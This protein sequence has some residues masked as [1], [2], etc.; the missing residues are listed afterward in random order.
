LLLYT[1]A[2][3]YL[4]DRSS[5]VAGV[6]APDAASIDGQERSDTVRV[7]E[8]RIVVMR[9]ADDDSGPG[10]AAAG[11]AA[12]RS[13]YKRPWLGVLLQ[14]VPLVGAASCAAN[15]ASSQQF[16]FEILLWWSVLFWGFGY[17]YLRRFR[18]FAVVFLAGPV[19]AFSACF[20]SFRG[21]TYD[22]EHCSNSSNS[23]GYK[24]NDLAS[25]NIASV[26][27]GL[28]VAALILFVAVDTWRLAAAH[29]RAIDDDDP[30]QPAPDGDEREL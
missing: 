7:R 30:E 28:I 18:R 8:S 3:E 24:C 27:T 10:S 9:I 14:C 22:Y 15:G 23:N 16:Y 5:S 11:K 2:W 6:K 21:V 20:A 19:L 13:G 29:N 4:A 1:A 26:Q 17:I 25:A 12:H